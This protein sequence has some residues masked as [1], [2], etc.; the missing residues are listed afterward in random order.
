MPYTGRE[1]W[2]EYKNRLE[3]YGYTQ[4][5]ISTVEKTR[6]HFEYAT[7]DQFTE[8]FQ[9]GLI[10]RVAKL[11]KKRHLYVNDVGEFLFLNHYHRKFQI[12][13]YFKTEE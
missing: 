6:E 3:S 1:N 10:T 5:E 9:Q 11:K 13:G 7:F 2:E 4:D 8:L 12:V